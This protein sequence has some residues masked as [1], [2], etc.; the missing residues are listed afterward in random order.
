MRQLAIALAVAGCLLLVLAAPNVQA[1]AG[2][3]SLTLRETLDNDP[4]AVCERSWTTDQIFHCRDLPWTSAFVGE[5]ADGD[6]FRGKGSGLLSY[7]LNMETLNGDLFGEFS[8]TFS[9][10]QDGVTFSGRF[11]GTFDGGV[12]HDFIWARGEGMQL[13]GHGDSVE[14]FQGVILIPHG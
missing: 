10:W 7:N 1:Q 12:I 6:E 2:T 13:M 8:W 3:L 5:F 14:G 9:D 11:T 4:T